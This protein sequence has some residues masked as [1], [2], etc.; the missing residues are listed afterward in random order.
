M[1]KEF[2]FLIWTISAS[3]LSKEKFFLR[4]NSISKACK[5]IENEI[6]LSGGIL[7][8]PVKI[9]FKNF[10]TA[11]KGYDELI[12]FLNNNNDIIATIGAGTRERDEYILNKININKILYFTFINEL[13]IQHKNIFII[14][15]TAR[16][17]K[18]K[19]AKHYLKNHTNEKNIFFLHEGKRFKEDFIKIFQNL[20]IKFNQVDLSAPEKIKNIERYLSNLIKEINT[21]DLIILDIKP[22]STLS[23]F[24]LLN[25]SSKKPTVLKFYGLIDG[26]IEKY[27]FP[28][29][30]VS[31]NRSANALSYASLCDAI[32]QNL[33]TEEK[34]FIFTSIYRIEIPLLIS[35]VLNKNKTKLNDHKSVIEK[36]PG[37][38]NSIDGINDVF[39]GKSRTYTFKNNINTNK[40]TYN[41]IFPKSLQKSGNLPRVF[42]PVQFL[43]YK[44]KFVKTDVNNIYID[45]IRITNIDIGEGI[46]SCE[47]FLDVLSVH[48]NPLEIIN[49][50]NLSMINSK[51]ETRLIKKTKDQ[52]YNS[53]NFR[54]YI[55]ANF[56]FLAIADNY[57]FDWQHIYISMSIT[58][59]EKYG[60][61][62]PVNESLLD[63]DF[64]L[65]GWRLIDAK[66]G[67]LRKKEVH[68]QNRTL[69]QVIQIR[70]EVRVGWT[71]ARTSVITTM[72]VAVPL[73]FLFFLNYYTVFLP[74]ADAKTAIGILTT[75]FLS[76]IAL[77]FSTEKPQPLRI[78][79]IDLIF[80]Y[81]YLQVGI[82][83]LITGITSFINEDIYNNS[84]ISMRYILPLSIIIALIFL[85]KR[86]KSVRLMPRID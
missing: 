4:S 43:N 73:I 62:E 21:N 20:N 86:I 1:I 25:K 10:S 49:F 17:P 77:Y 53:Y 55:V 8:K 82:T 65:D 36:T 79:T 15:E 46:W 71:I 44:N 60:I 29:I 3:T 83:V 56:D 81:Y 74:F 5:I 38:I 34:S 50:N 68:H 54:F 63:Y 76:G 7:D 58:D 13:N 35:Y 31:N 84:M 52:S 78:T 33:S 80:I 9:I 40:I 72:K 22:T 70:E 48:E 47:F 57:P 23:L 61:I 14:S 67:V 66:T 59:Y 45:I 6:N 18:L 2:K 64:Q 39:I 11:P 69:D 28:L 27:K 51:F 26:R 16:D 30:E 75:T 24:N 37:L 12:E 19:F 32:D 41:Y 42:Y 85:Y